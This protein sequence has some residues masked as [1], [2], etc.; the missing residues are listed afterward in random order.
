[1]YCG[2]ERDHGQLGSDAKSLSVIN[3]STW[4]YGIDASPAIGDRSNTYRPSKCC[5]VIGRKHELRYV[6]LHKEV[7][8]TIDKREKD[9]P[10]N[11]NEGGE[12]FKPFCG[13]RMILNLNLVGG[14]WLLVKHEKIN[15]TSVSVRRFGKLSIVS[16]NVSTSR[17]L[18]AQELSRWVEEMEKETLVTKQ[19]WA[20]GIDWK[21]SNLT[22]L[23]WEHTSRLISVT[24]SHTIK[25]WSWRKVTTRE[26]KTAFFSVQKY[27]GHRIGEG[28][29]HVRLELLLASATQRNNEN[30]VQRTRRAVSVTR[31]ETYPSS[32]SSPVETCLAL[33]DLGLFPQ[34]MKVDS[35][36]IHLL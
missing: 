34:A 11:S 19:T 2:P 31:L 14:C 22:I 24:S 15:L 28:E 12:S 16:W 35:F 3:L 4:W 36:H 5:H 25:L 8:H 1:L 26:E 23:L 10:L 7:H 13:T 18:V 6:V 20:N 29:T 30:W 9:L 27:Q 32:A 17:R 33:P 21:R